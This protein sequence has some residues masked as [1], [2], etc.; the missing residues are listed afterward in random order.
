MDLTLNSTSEAPLQ[1]SLGFEECVDEIPFESAPPEQW[2]YLLF[3]ETV[4]NNQS[5]NTSC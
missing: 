1:L 4:E 2:L 5:S 3:C